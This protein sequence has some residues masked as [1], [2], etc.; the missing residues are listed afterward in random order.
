MACRTGLFEVLQSSAE[1]FF[2]ES[3]GNLDLCGVCSDGTLHGGGQSP[4]G[5]RIMRL[6]GSDV[7][8]A[9]IDEDDAGDDHRG[10]TEHKANE[11]VRGSS[12]ILGRF[13]DGPGVK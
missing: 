4:A 7:V 5:D 8:D 12:S 13:R 2:G 6:C 9:G 1:L 11:N 3:C 10:E